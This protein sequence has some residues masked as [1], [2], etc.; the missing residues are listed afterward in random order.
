MDK[1]EGKATFEARLQAARTRQGLDATPHEGPTGGA[2]P[3]GMGTRVGVEMVAALAVG[4]GIGWGLDRWLHTLPLFLVVFILLGGA[5]G[6]A[7]VW[8]MVG[9]PR[10]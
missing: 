5:A 9:P 10:R 4:T 6:I 8:R 7:N 3:W 1:D 2:S